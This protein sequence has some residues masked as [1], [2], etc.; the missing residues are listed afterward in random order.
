MKITE[1]TTLG[2]LA[3]HLTSR[4]VVF[5]TLRIATDGGAI[6][7]MGYPSS[8]TPARGVGA[9]IAEAFQLAIEQVHS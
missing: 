2:E 1:S 4:G 8:P 9:S 6:V 3:V 5:T 7:T